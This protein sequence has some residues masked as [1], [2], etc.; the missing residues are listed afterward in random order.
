MKTVFDLSKNE[1]ATIKKLHGSAAL[2]MRLISL[3]VTPH[4]ALTVLECAASKQTIQIEVGDVR[5]ALRENEAK[6]VEVA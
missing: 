6:L 5:L 1:T 2:K 3:G 4:A